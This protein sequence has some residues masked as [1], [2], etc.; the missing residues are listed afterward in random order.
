[1]QVPRLETHGFEWGGLAPFS[2]ETWCV[3]SRIMRQYD[4]DQNS[5]RKHMD[6][7]ENEID[8]VT[9]IHNSRASACAPDLSL[10]DM[11]HEEWMRIVRRVCGRRPIL[12]RAQLHMHNIRR[13]GPLHVDAERARA[14]L[15][16]VV[17]SLYDDLLAGATVIYPPQT[18][19]AAAP[20][21]L[22]VAV[23]APSRHFFVMDANTLHYRRGTRSRVARRMFILTFSDRSVTGVGW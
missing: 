10:E 11:F 20:S 14:H 2:K 9:L 23:A 3:L 1:M 19:E 17:I 7:I 15:C 5:L 12:V 22:P 18:S 4:D 13:D 21:A 8:V 16:N 6:R